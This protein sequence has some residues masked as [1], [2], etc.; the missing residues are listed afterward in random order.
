M[1]SSTVSSNGPVPH[2]SVV[3][4]VNEQP[5]SYPALDPHMDMYAAEGGFCP[6]TAMLVK[7]IQ[8]NSGLAHEVFQVM[9]KCLV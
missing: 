3:Q 4:H 9:G 6:S 8:D 7:F 5:Q 1:D 2:S